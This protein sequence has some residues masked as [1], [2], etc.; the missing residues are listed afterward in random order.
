MLVALQKS[1]CIVSFSGGRDSSAMLALAAF[2]A[3][4]E[5]LP[6]P[7]PVTFRFPEIPSTH[8]SEWQEMVVRHVG[9]EHWERLDL[10]SELDLLGDTA[11][12]CLTRHGVAWP[13]N[14]YFH[15]PVFQAA[16][17]GSVVTGVDGDGLFGDW[18]WCHAQAVLHRRVPFEMRD[19]ARMGFAFA[20]PPVRRLAINQRQH[21]VPPWLRPGAQRDFSAAV[22]S[23]AVGEPRRWDRRVAWH[24]SSRALFIAL[25]NLALIA[26]DSNVTVIHPFLDPGFLGALAAEGGAVGFGDRTSAMAHLFADLLPTE[27]IGRSTK[28]EFGR[29]V[30][31][32]GA[33]AFAST[34]DGSGVDHAMVD[35]DLLRAAWSVENPV[36]HSWTLLH[37]A[38]LASQ[39]L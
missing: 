2:V 31:R 19:V 33:R 30:W 5:G 6:L 3:R 29:A 24:A 38:W 4:R 26:A 11:R 28:A 12:A 39:S 14:A 15:V 16:Q 23:R 37:Q 18:R 10:T 17:G 8:E 36:I 7:V 27:T 20:P 22:I 13:P 25:A 35:P 34:W 1:P 21:F 9:L 32:Q